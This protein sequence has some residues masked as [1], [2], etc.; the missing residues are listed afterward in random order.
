M[1]SDSYVFE[2][3]NTTGKINLSL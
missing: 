2:D 1:R 3:G